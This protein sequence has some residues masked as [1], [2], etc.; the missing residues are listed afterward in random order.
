MPP[1]RSLLKGFDI[2]SVKKSRVGNDLRHNSPAS[3]RIPSQLHFDN[4]W[5]SRRFDCQDVRVSGSKYDFIAQDREPG[6]FMGHVDKG[7]Q[8]NVFVRSEPG[9]S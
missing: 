1:E 9:F 7:F 5:A 4:H 6:L 8:P 2:E 3:L